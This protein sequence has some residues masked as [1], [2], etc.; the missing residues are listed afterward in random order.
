VIPFHK[1]VK[2]ITAVRHEEDGKIVFVEQRLGR[3]LEYFRRWHIALAKERLPKDEKGALAKAAA[4]IKLVKERGGWPDEM[5]L[6]TARDQ[7]QK[8]KERDKSRSAK[9]SRSKRGKK[10]DG[11]RGA[12]FR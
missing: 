4:A 11:R 6:R 8:W 9:Y 1:G 12:R 10:K 5:T 7:Y 3:A 2:S